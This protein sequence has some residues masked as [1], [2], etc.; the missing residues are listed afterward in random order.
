M[1]WFKRN[2]KKIL[3]GFVIVLALAAAYIFYPVHEDLSS[4]KDRAANY[5]VKILR[6]AYGVPHVFGHTDADAAYGLAYAHS[7]D[8]FLTIQ[9][10]LL[11]AR[12]DLATVYGPESAPADYLVAF[13]RV[14]DVVDSQY[15]KLDAPTRAICE[16][17]ADGLNVYAAHHPDEALL[18]LF[19]VTGK[20][21]VAASVEK[22]P[23]FFGLDETIG[24]LFSDNPEPVPTPT[25]V[26]YNWLFSMSPFTTENTESTENLKNL[27]SVNSVRSVVRIPEPTAQL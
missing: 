27:F 8:D 18:G 2:W 14:W 12:G 22:S 26:S 4:L 6:D 10:V 17:Y 15:D 19:P 3:I 23:L 20:D 16:A 7:E 13:L 24:H 11:A 5:D 21:I 1:N 25:K 9:Q